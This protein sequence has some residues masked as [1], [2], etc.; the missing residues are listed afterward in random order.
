M[1]DYLD[2]YDEALAVYEQALRL[3]PQDEDLYLAQARV[4]VS[5]KRFDEALV[6]CQRAQE[7]APTKPSVYKERGDIQTSQ[8]QYAEALAAYQKAV[9]LDPDDAFL[10]EQVG[11]TLCELERFAEAVKA[12]G[13]ALRLSPGFIR[14]SNSQARALEKLGRYEQALSAYN[15]ALEQSPKQFSLLV[16]RASVLKKLLRYE[17]ANADYVRAELLD[18]HSFYNI[19]CILGKVDLKQVAEAKARLQAAGKELSDEAI[20]AEITL[21]YQEKKAAELK[22]SLRSSPLFQP[23]CALM[24]ERREWSG[25]A[26]QFKELLCG[27]F[28]DAFAKWYRSPHKFVDELKRIAPELRQEGIG[29]GAPPEA[30]LVTLTGE[31]TAS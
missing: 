10:Y 15:K 8:K 17:E 4:L 27:Q 3:D 25:T 21:M 2:C 16:G 30:T 20:E 6:A 31:A 13:R 11:D 19:I 5:L 22:A 9:E 29:V 24:Q 1:L 14:V 18:P 7:L 28:P 12:Y 26:K 23:V